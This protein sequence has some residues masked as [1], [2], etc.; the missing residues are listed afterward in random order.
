MGFR[1][2]TQLNG[3]GPANAAGELMV[4]GGKILLNNQSGRYSSQAAGSVG[5]VKALLQSL[6]QTVEITGPL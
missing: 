2:Y 1:V 6:D 5:R 4:S 3:G